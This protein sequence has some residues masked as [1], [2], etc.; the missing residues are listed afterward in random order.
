MNVAVISW[1]RPLG[2][3]IHEPVRYQLVVIGRERTHGLV[4]ASNGA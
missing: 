2:A 4:T 3:A 1:A